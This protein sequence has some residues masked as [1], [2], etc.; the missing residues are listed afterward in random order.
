[1]PTVRDQNVTLRT[2]VSA[3]D[4]SV[5]W[6]IKCLNCGA[7]LAGPFCAECGQRAVPPN[8][9]VKELAGDAF[10]ELSGWDG[11][12]ADTFRKLLTKPGQLTQEWI[13]GRRV[14]FI[15][16]VR[17]Y[18]TASFLYFL[19]SAGS[20]NVRTSGNQI[21]VGGLRIGS[22]SSKAER[23]GKAT[24][25]AIASREAP[26]G[27]ELDSALAEAESA[28]RLLRPMFKRAVT[29]PVGFRASIMSTMPKVFFVLVPAFGLVL[30]LFYRGRH[31]PEHLY[32]AIHFFAFFFIARALGNLALYTHSVA[33][34]A[35]VQVL[36]VVWII[37]YA[38][39]SVR[40]VYGGSAAMTILKGIA[41]CV[42]YGLI[43]LPLMVA[44]VIVAAG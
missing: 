38:F 28:P 43:A 29:D 42:V 41:I 34:T 4:H 13:E 17:L 35:I 2:S 36:M 21:E 37:W 10:S 30:A 11:K 5:S 6:K 20:P 15:A 12:L 1:M 39:T 14:L 19:V 40:L 44:G 27:A 26:K 25:D 7:A 22:S 16:P 31:Y 33:L 9:T 18:L 32:F 3:D 24:Q 8:P 23:L